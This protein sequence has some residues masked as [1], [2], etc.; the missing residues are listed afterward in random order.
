M[1]LPKNKT[2]FMAIIGREKEIEEFMHLYDSGKAE[3]VAIY[4]RRRVGKTFGLKF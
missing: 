3:F 1:Y 4:G 2:A